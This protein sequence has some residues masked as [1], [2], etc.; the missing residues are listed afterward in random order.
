MFQNMIVILS[1]MM[2]QKFGNIDLLFWGF[3]NSLK[4][5]EKTFVIFILVV[6]LS[7][8]VNIFSS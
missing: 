8:G 6:I 1:C 3:F 4:Y 7:L 5:S 2:L